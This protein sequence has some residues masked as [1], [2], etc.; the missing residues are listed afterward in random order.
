MVH[1]PENVP[2]YATFVPNIK[3]LYSISQLLFFLCSIFFGLLLSIF[4]EL[5]SGILAFWK[6]P[7]DFVEWYFSVCFVL[8]SGSIVPLWFF[9]KWLLRLAHC[10]PFQAAFFTPV[11]IYL[12]RLSLLD[13]INLLL[14]QLFWVFFLFSFQEIMWHKGV[15]RLTM[16]GG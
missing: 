15:K 16:S 4:F 5:I 3:S 12:D 9:P 13:T 11:Q 7:G 1:M 2:I 10:L 8:L 6:V 14:I